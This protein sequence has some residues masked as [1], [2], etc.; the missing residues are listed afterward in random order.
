M[1]HTVADW[2]HISP[3]EV[4]GLI[5]NEAFLRPHKQREGL[6]DNRFE[7]RQQLDCA[8]VHSVLMLC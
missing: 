8:F 2:L 7:H 6:P 5:A 4:P 1:A 3:L